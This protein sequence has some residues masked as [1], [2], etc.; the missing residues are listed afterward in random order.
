KMDH[1]G[2]D[3]NS[4]KS[5]RGSAPIAPVIGDDN[6][7]MGLTNDMIIYGAKVHLC[8]DTEVDVKNIT[9]S[10]SPAYGRPFAEIFKDAGH[11]FYK[12]D[13][14]IFAPAEVSIENTQTGKIKR[15]GTINSEVLKKAMEK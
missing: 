2:Y 7:M 14:G 10:S 9:S 11:N 3:V 8:T 6:A 15:A 5:G 12:I 1:L 13:P 4:V